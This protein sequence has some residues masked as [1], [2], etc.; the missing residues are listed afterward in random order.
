MPS[1]GVFPAPMLV[2]DL[3]IDFPLYLA[4]MAGIT[5]ISFR[6]LMRS[7]G[8]GAVVTELISSEALTRESERTR[9]M[10]RVH[11]DERPVGI[12]IFG[13][14]PEAMAETAARVEQVGADF[15]DI[16]LGCPV[17]KVVKQNAGAHLLQDLPALSKILTAVRRAI[18]VPLTIKIRTG[19]INEELTYPDVIRVAQDAG[20]A[21]VAI[22]GRTREQAY[23]GKANWEHIRDAKGQAQIPIIGNGDLLNA[24]QVL[25]LWQ[26]SD[27]DGMMIGRAA[28]RNPWIFLEVRALLRGESTET[29][30]HDLPKLLCQHAELLREYE[31]PRQASLKLKKFLAWYC[32]GM[33]H[34]SKFRGAL[35]AMETMEEVMERSLDFFAKHDRQDWRASLGEDE[36]FLMGG[37]G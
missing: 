7:M 37:H 27:C 4:P 24:R 17:R 34:S 13:S 2:D 26:Q 19:F 22:H 14:S 12:Q 1:A 5:D 36:R 10:I 15:V 20:V 8:C 25:R 23:E 32:T 30:E 29:I 3:R 31:I 16:N 9:R 35:F 33:P 11:E 18:S 21:A 28:L 6:T